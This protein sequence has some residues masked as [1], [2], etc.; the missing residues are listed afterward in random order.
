MNKILIT[1]SNRGLGWGIAK[2]FHEKGWE[3][4]SLNRTLRDVDWLNEIKCDLED[5]NQIETAI[6]K[7]LEHG[8]IEVCVF[9]AA[10]RRFDLIEKMS[11]ED[12]NASININ[13]T[14]IFYLL[15]KMLPVLRIN[16]GYAFF[17]GSQASDNFFEKGAAYCA[18]KAALK[19][20]VEVMI[21]ENRNYGVR[22]T[23]LNAGAIKN[24]LKTN[25]EWKM[26]PEKVAELILELV[27]SDK[28]LLINELVL[29][30]AIVPEHPLFGIDRIQS[31]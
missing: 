29:S 1:G 3:V 31:I 30:P 25:D 11:L 9:N 27:L 23:I 10:V 8:N 5:V 4:I 21:M 7:V 6:E 28:S 2:T 24:R 12:W 13:L 22:A 20:L 15:R 19:A 17:I 26:K 18:S 14:S 16:K